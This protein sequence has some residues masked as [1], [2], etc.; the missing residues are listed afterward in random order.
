ML[1]KLIIVIVT[2]KTL[3]IVLMAIVL[4][5]RGG[6]FCALHELEYGAKC[7]VRNCTTQKMAGTQACIQHNAEWL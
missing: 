2:Y 3:S 4:Q 6:V 5:P 1:I 7:H